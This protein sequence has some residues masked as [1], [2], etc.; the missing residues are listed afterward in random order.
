MKN[1]QNNYASYPVCLK[2][3]SY[4]FKQIDNTFFLKIS[5]NC[6]GSDLIHVVIFQKKEG[7][8]LV[9]EGLHIDKKRIRQPQYQQLLVE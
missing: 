1:C 4:L 8:C 2:T 5:V 7:G 3:W 6:E 9:R